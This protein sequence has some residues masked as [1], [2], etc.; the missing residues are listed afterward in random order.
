MLRFIGFEVNRLK[1]KGSFRMRFIAITLLIIFL[2]IYNG[3]ADASGFLFI[4]IV[5]V[6]GAKFAPLMTLGYFY[7]LVAML[8]F[9]YI[10]KSIIEDFENQFD[11]E[12]FT[13]FNTLQYYL[14]KSV[15]LFLLNI[16]L[17]LVF[18]LFSYISSFAVHGWNPGGHMIDSFILY[19]IVMIAALFT[20]LLACALLFTAV[21]VAIKKCLKVRIASFITILLVVLMVA[22][23]GLAEFSEHFITSNFGIL[24]YSPRFVLGNIANL[25]WRLDVMDIMMWFSISLF[26]WGA[27]PILAV[28][29]AQRFL[30]AK[31]KNTSILENGH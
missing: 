23:G 6:R 1:H 3:A 12:F 21:A 2:A 17:S 29:I 19:N 24:L 30:R 7:S 31:V 26:V 20:S 18:L 11:K 25:Y 27:F 16:Y 5:M 22:L 8:G 4:D 9:A 13:M 14:Y 10:S 28:I 15:V